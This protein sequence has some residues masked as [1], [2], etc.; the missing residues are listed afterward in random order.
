MEG[1]SIVSILVVVSL[2]VDK[3]TKMQGWNAVTAEITSKYVV[4]DDDQS[5]KK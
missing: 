2:L 3:Y 4:K 1:V 5:E